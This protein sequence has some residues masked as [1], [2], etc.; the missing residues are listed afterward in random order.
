[1]GRVSEIES[2]LGRLRIELIE[3]EAHATSTRAR[4]HARELAIARPQQQIKV[5][6]EQVQ[7]LEARP[8]VVGAELQALDARREPARVALEARRHAAAEA[9]AE[10]DRAEQ[11]LADETEA[12]ATAHREIEGLEADVEAARSEVF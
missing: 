5:D 9:L 2:D 8:A 3:A 11:S 6:Y 4:A 7:S 1:A 12:Y 10:R